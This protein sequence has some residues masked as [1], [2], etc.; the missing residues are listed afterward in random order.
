MVDK[1]SIIT[2]T[3]FT[4]YKYLVFVS[5]QVMELTEKE[6]NNFVYVMLYNIYKI[7]I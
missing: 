7:V 1:E 5:A 6:Q 4:K 3:N 2:I